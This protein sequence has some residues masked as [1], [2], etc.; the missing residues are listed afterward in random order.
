M[1]DDSKLRAYLFTMEI[2]GI[3]TVRFQKC[4]GLEA[5]TYS[6]TMLIT[7]TTSKSCL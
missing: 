2:D 1:S 7:Q 5:E 3:E 6:E 4:E